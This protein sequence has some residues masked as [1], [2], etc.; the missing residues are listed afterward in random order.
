MT[1]KVSFTAR[2]VASL[3]HFTLLALSPSKNIKAFSSGALLS[4]I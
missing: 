1:N 2:E 4:A 3:T